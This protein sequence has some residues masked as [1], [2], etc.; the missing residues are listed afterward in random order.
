VLY[1]ARDDEPERHQGVIVRVEASPFAPSARLLE[2]F[3]AGVVDGAGFTRRSIWELRQLWNRE[4]R[5][6]LEVI[7]L[8]TG[9][10]HCTITDGYGDAPYA[11]R[12]TLA[13]ALKQIAKMQRDEVRRRARGGRGADHAAAQAG[14]TRL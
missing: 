5:V 8:A 12:R 1:V 6:F 4:R 13:T 7:D 10:T 9:G 3:G 14:L 2:D 11:P